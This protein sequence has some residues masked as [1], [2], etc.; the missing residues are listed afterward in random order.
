MLSHF[1]E[2][3]LYHHQSIV[4]HASNYRTDYGNLR[5]IYTVTVRYMVGIKKAN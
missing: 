2:I 3:L 1:P 5:V 4:K